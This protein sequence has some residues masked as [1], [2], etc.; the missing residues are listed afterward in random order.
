MESPLFPFSFSL[1]PPF[2]RRRRKPL[3]PPLPL[4]PL[5]PFFPTRARAEKKTALFPRRKGEEESE[6]FLPLLL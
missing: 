4:S 6:S 1:P 2:S 5:P 3:S